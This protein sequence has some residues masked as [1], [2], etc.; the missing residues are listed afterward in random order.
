MKTFA[1]GVQ[2]LVIR[3]AGTIPGPI[4]FGTFID[5]TCILWQVRQ[6]DKT[7]GSC[8][9]YDSEQMAINV[10]AISKPLVS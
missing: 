9:L 1:L 2:W 6:C 4:L 7:Q 8:W 3:A 10:L 5:L